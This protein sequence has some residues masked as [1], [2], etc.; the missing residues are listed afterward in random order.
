MKKCL[1]C[2]GI[3]NPPIGWRVFIGLENPSLLCERCHERILFIAGD[4]CRKCGRPF[5]LFPEKYRHG[6]TCLDCV[7]WE[8][9]GSSIKKNRSI[10]VYNPFAKELIA[11]YKYRGDAELVKA[12]EDPIRTLAKKEFQK[13]LFV[14][15]P[16]SEERHYERGFNQADVI[17][18]L[19]GK[20]I[21]RCL[22]RPINE[23]KQ[24][25]KSRAD[26]LRYQTVLSFDSTFTEKINGRDI[27]L[28]DDIYTTGSTVEAAGKILID[29]GARTV[30]SFTLARG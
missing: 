1:Y 26:R 13:S 30:F 6:D 9:S 23:K 12:F 28:V 8:K 15:I 21:I 24:S 4:L 14:P 19:I 20:E 3:Y 18:Q 27:T 7:K 25:K 22:T 29:Y 16:L 11:K 17:A 10:I 5:S 2:N